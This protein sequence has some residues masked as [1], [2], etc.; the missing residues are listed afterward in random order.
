MRQG[1]LD[2]WRGACMIP[3]DFLAYGI[4]MFIMNNFPIPSF[5]YSSKS[6]KLLPC[7]QDS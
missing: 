3:Q 1:I 4:R 2:V 5:S 7:R 6:M